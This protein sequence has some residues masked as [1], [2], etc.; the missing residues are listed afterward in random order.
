MPAEQ[1]LPPTHDGPHLDAAEQA[2]AG[3]LPAVQA[4]PPPH[5]TLVRDLVCPDYDTLPTAQVVLPAPHG[6]LHDDPLH[7]LKSAPQPQNFL[8]LER[9]H[10]LRRLL[11]QLELQRTEDRCNVVEV[12]II[13]TISQLTRKIKNGTLNMNPKQ[14]PILIY[15]P[16]NRQ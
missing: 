5:P 3:P 4:Q 14:L 10:R 13:C 9:K 8:A 2:Q 1:A 11:Q 16:P 6:H 12:G 7:R 15:E